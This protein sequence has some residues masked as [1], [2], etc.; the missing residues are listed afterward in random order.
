MNSFYNTPRNGLL[1][2]GNELIIPY[3]LLRKDKLLLLPPSGIRKYKDDVILQSYT[4]GCGEKLI[5]TYL[6][7]VPKK[8][9]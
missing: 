3:N 9:V 6:I 5:K 1:L 4:E 7:A 8:G 2:A